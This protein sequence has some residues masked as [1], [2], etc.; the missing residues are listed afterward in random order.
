MGIAATR[1]GGSCPNLINRGIRIRS[2]LEPPIKTWKVARS[3]EE[4]LTEFG[5]HSEWGTLHFSAPSDVQHQAGTSS[6]LRRHFSEKGT[7]RNHVDTSF[8]RIM[9]DEPVFAFAK[10]FKLANSTG[11]RTTKEDSVLFTFCSHPGTRGPVCF[12]Q[13]TDVYAAAVGL[14]FL[15]CGRVDW[16]SLQRFQDGGG[17]GQQLLR[18]PSRRTPSSRGRTTIETSLRFPPV[19]CSA[20][21]SSRV[22]PTAHFCL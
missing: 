16:L 6:L 18:I 17:A 22:R 11:Q 15:V 21:P 7:L 4:L 13:R 14:V 19:R 20:L 10:S 12:R 8:R 2:S 9:E 3:N 5:D 1:S